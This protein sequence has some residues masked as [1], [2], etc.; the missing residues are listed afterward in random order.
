MVLA[1]ERF[2][3][4]LGETAPRARASDFYHLG[5]LLPDPDVVLRKQGRDLSLY[6]GL[7]TDAHVWSC[8]QSR[9]SGVLSSEWEVREAEGGGPG[10]RRARDLAQRVL[11]RLPVHRIISDMLEAPFYGVSPMEVVWGEESGLWVPRDVIGRPVSWFAFDADNALRFL[12]QDAPIDGERPPDRKF[13]VVAHHASYQ[14]PYGERLLARCFWPVTFKKQG[15]KF[16]AVF[17][18]KFGM[19]WVV[20]KVPRSTGE[21]ERRGVL[22]GLQQMVQ[23]AVAVINDDQSVDFPESAGKSASGELYERLIKMANRE[24]SKAILGQTLTTEIDGG[25]SY[26]AAGVHL[27]V[28][29]DL[30]DQDKRA[31]TQAFNQILAWMTELNFVNAQPPTFAFY[32]EEDVKTAR[33]K[34]DEILVRQGLRLSRE[35]YRRTYHFNETDL[36]GQE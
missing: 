3:A 21:D 18:E 28:R 33:A 6:T 36:E 10:A 7:L 9:K 8:Y 27:S 16:W 34:R 24:I 35:Y 29:L 25:G 30:I 17:T 14:N 26:A 1:D 22:D 31:V 2:Q 4:L 12:S 5:G 13:V 15:L 20:G 11:D 32:E 19:P 23:D